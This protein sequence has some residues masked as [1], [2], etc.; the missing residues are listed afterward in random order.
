MIY[1][2]LLK[3]KFQSWDSLEKEIEKLPS[4]YDKGEVFE[5]FI[6]AYLLLNSQ[7]YQIRE[8]YR[9][10]EIPEK[11]LKKYKLEKRDSGVDGLMILNND[12]A[13][14]YQVKFRSQ[15][16]KP[17]YDELA[18]FWVEAQHTDI[19]YTIANCYSL[20]NLTK[21]Q[22]KH[23]QILVDDFDL[24]DED[25]FEMLFTLTTKS[26]IKKAKKFTPFD[27]QDKIINDVVNGFKAT[28][29]GKV[30]AACGTGKTLTSLWI[31][32][33]LKAKN[34]LFLAPNLALIKQTLEAWSLQSERPFSYLAVCSDTTVSLSQD[35]GDMAISE[36]N[37]PVT[38]DAT[39]ILNFL[40]VESGQEKY[41]FST[42]QSLPSIL[43][44]FMRI[45]D[46]AF[47][48]IIFDEAHRT[49]GAKYSNLFSLALDDNNIPS[50]KRLFMTA[51]QRMLKPKLKKVAAE[52]N[53]LVFSMDDEKVYGKLFHSY[54]F[55]KAIEDGVIS[56]Y[57]I[58]VAGIQEEELSSW[59]IK[60]K[61]LEVSSKME[62]TSFTTAQTLF[63]QVVLA[64]ALESYPIKKV[65]SFHS[66]VN[67]A[68]V[69][70]GNI[71]NG[72]NLNELIISVNKSIKSS[73]LYIEHING[74][75]SAGHRK[76]ILDN[77]K[78]SNY[79]IVS[80][81]R[82]LT[83]GVD[84]P[85]ID[86]VYFVDSKN[87][88]IDIVQA[89]GRALRKPKDLDNKTAFFI[90]PIL[91]PENSTSSDIVNMESFEMVYSVLQALRDQDDRLDEW[92]NEIN[93]G[94]VKGKFA[95]YWKNKKNPLKFSLPSNINIDD[96]TD[97]LYLKI[98]TV[99]A[100][101]TESLFNPIKKYGK[102][103]R[104]SGY[105]RIFKTLGDYSVDAYFKSLVHPTINKYKA[106]ESSLTLTNIEAKINNNNVSHT[107]KLGLIVK[108]KKQ[109]DLTPL[110]KKYM[111]GEIDDMTL[112][113]RQMLRYSTYLED[114]DESRLL[115]PYRACLKIIEQT[116]SLN[117]FEFAFGVNTLYDSKSSSIQ[118]AI[119]S[120]LILRKKYPNL[121]LVNEA[122]RLTILDELNLSFNSE[123]SLT[124]I[125]TKRTT[126]YN[127]Y[128][129]FKNHLSIFSDF[130]EIKNQ[131]IYLISGKSNKLNQL[132]ALDN[133][134]EY[135]INHQSVMERYISPFF[136]FV[137]FSL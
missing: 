110:G 3:N 62:D 126:L 99:N 77:F 16:K 23:L 109:Y 51:T 81:S 128:N 101:P 84:I 52:N 92:I 53:R 18:K 13:A 56:D 115:F 71:G 74:S 39:E 120:I 15:R 82:C 41:I 57:E 40:H 93:Q 14:G 78:N 34:I 88:I 59:I 46:F 135:E 106:L 6:Y 136:S 45:D 70:S 44:A 49:A 47:D 38:T 37:I 30:I 25:F 123:Y 42:Y 75:M 11:Y 111:S 102:K 63:S 97:K 112:F 119:D 94:A 96:F 65:I 21:K 29:R 17:S 50:N 90:I 114:L 95:K 19:N 55:G 125:W 10:T 43:G 54:N 32:E 68:K 2:N 69:F 5:Q 24:L 73:D 28:N 133:K 48:L 91:I 89:C 105:K 26:K 80:N 8:L 35:D 122:N 61:E 108:N 85:I 129:Y 20:T 7:L 64:K 79:G 87:S 12:K 83:E 118:E 27:F 104:K 66:S 124:D 130:I 4:T 100:N 116:K 86:S 67:N 33:R 22:E 117:F 36:L 58:I 107:V 134:L 98:A 72:S 121:L 60:N 113:K 131:S 103:D 1:H 127:Q 137:I 31:T 132:L 9:S 76:E